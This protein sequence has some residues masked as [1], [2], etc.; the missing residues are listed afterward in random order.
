MSVSLGP[1]PGLATEQQQGTIRVRRR[2]PCASPPNGWY[3]GVQRCCELLS[4][5][6]SALEWRQVLAGA[7]GAERAA[8]LGH[9]DALLEM[10]RAAEFEQVRL[11]FHTLQRL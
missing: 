6:T 7:N 1:M 5:L 11:L 4:W 2:C 9:L 10:P 8:Q 3:A